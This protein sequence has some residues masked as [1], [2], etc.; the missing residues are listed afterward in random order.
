LQGL[1][2]LFKERDFERAGIEGARMEWGSVADWIGGIGGAGGAGSAAAF[3]LMDRRRQYRE[4]RARRNEETVNRSIVM[5][6]FRSTVSSS[7]ASLG[8]IDD[9]GGVSESAWQYH[10]GIL[11]NHRSRLRELSAV[12]RDLRLQLAIDKAAHSLTFS[13]L[14]L[15]HTSLWF[16]NVAIAE[17][18]LQAAI[19][20]LDGS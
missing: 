18:E 5:D 7:L 3:Y 14:P 2:G 1:E 19:E 17:G 13:N 11:S 8:Q 16:E 12:A 6:E 20:L 4:Q 10:N 15:E 9:T